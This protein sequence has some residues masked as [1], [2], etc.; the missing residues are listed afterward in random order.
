[1]THKV[2]GFAI[3]A[4]GTT[5][6]LAAMSP[7][8]YDHSTETALSGT[9]LHVVTAAS[10]D[11]TFGVHLDLQTKDGV[12]YVALGPAMFIGVNNFFV[13]AGDRVQIIGSRIREDGGAVYAR[14]IS[15]GATMLVLRDEEGGPKWT[16]AIEGTDGCGVVHQPLARFTE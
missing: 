7:F 16:P 1:M 11:G 6:S 13:Y 9:V 12:V 3:V 2:L 8:S 15:K 10:T 4:M 14:T 5:L